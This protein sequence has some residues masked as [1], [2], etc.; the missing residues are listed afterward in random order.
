MVCLSHFP[1]RICRVK[2]PSEKFLKETDKNFGVSKLDEAELFAAQL[3]ANFSIKSGMSPAKDQKKAGTCTSFG[4]VSCLDYVHGRIDLSEAHLTHVA[5]KKYGDC[6]EG[7]AL[8]HA[9]YVAKNIGVVEES[10]WPYD[11]DQ[12][13]WTTP[14]NIESLP[15]FKFSGINY[16]FDKKVQ[17][18]VI[19]IKMAFEGSLFDL[20]A[21]SG[22]RI[23]KTKQVLTKIKR[24]IA[25]VV[26]V[27]W[28]KDHQLDAGWEDGPDIQMP[29]RLNL[30]LWI[31]SSSTSTDK[32][33]HVI[34]ICGYDD[35][36][37]RFEFK[38][39]WHSWWGDNGFGTIPYEYVNA[40]ARTAMYGW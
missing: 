27:W 28:K 13:C 8:E 6:T 17:N 26:P 39:S 11:D 40:F 5:E 20:A 31:D 35:K 24:P 16:V 36:T 29:T 34:T 9:M 25:M 4:V 10:H 33:W 37:D 1:N 22:S 21:S 14:P 2:E 30:Q 3:P 12:I 19:D 18:V 15:K 38:N 23:T 32:G 7:L